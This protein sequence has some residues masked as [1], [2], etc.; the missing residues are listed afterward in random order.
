LIQQFEDKAIASKFEKRAIQGE[1]RAKKEPSMA[2]MYRE[3]GQKIPVKPY[4]PVSVKG[5]PETVEGATMIEGESKTK[6]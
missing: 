3:L 1:P 6:T 4:H 2:I 5:E